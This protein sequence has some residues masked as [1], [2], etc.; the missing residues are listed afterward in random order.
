MSFRRVHSQCI[1]ANSQS[2]NDETDYLQIFE[3]SL[4]I[5]ILNVY[6]SDKE[7]SYDLAGCLRKFSSLRLQQKI[8]G[9]CGCFHGDVSFFSF[10]DALA[11]LCDQLDGYVTFVW[12]DMMSEGKK[13]HLIGIDLIL[14]AFHQFRALFLNKLK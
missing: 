11:F 9:S 14:E 4:G 7:S 6:H 8:S 1:E 2:S 5:L 10:L 13:G 12:K 3:D